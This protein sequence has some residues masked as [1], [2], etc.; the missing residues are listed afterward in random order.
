MSR[1]WRW[2]WPGNAYKTCLAAYTDEY[3]LRQATKFRKKPRAWDYERRIPRRKFRAEISSWLGKWRI[4]AENSWRFRNC[5][6]GSKTR[7]EQERRPREESAKIQAKTGESS[8]RARVSQ[9]LFTMS[10][11]LKTPRWC[12]QPRLFFINSLATV[13]YLSDLDGSAHP[14]S[15]GS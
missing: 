9:S 11:C 4:A 15:P 12:R 2:R 6:G 10:H 13:Y 5:A 14:K 1:F 7:Q 8:M 3:P